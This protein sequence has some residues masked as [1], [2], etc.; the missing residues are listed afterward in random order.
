MAFEDVNFHA[1]EVDWNFWLGNPGEP[2][3]VFFCCDYGIEVPFGGSA[4]EVFQFTKA[5]AMVVCEGF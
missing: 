1:K 5:V 4:D 3:G 2:D